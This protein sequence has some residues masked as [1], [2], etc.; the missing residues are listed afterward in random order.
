[1][2][3]KNFKLIEK[4]ALTHDVF[5]LVFETDEKFVIKSWQFITFLLDK[6]WWRAYS[7]LS[8]EKEKVSFIIKKRELENGWRWWS[9]FICELKIGETLKWVWPAGHFLLQENNKNKLF[10]WTGT[11]IVPLW[12]QINWSLK[13]NIDYKSKLLF[14]LKTKDDVFYEEEL[15]KLK[16]KNKNFDYDICLSRENL[17]LYHKWY[18]V[19]LID[20]NTIKEFEEFYICWAP[21][22][23]DSTIEKLKNLW[24]SEENIFFEKY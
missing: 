23:I 16:E 19:D 17:D 5:E 15:K 14:W 2:G 21:A 11:W 13:E 1:M 24:V 10:I 4:K 3:V 6:I 7:I 9:K 20:K 12:N 18:T 8:L 22:M